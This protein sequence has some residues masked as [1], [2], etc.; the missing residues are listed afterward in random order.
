M[1]NNDEYIRVATTYYKIVHEPNIHDED[2]S[3][4][5][6]AKWDKSSIIDDMGKS[7][8]KKIK[9]YDG[10]INYPS[11]VNYKT[12]V[13]GF[14]NEYHELS[15]AIEKGEFPYT[16]K[17]LKHIFGDFYM[18]GLD[19]LSILWQKPTQLL[20]V[21]CLVSLNRN[22]GKTTF[23]NWLR[24]LFESNVAIIKKVDFKSRFNEAWINKL[25]V[26]VD[27]AKFDK[28]EETDY[29]KELSTSKTQQREKK[30]VDQKQENYFGKIILAS[31]NIDDFIVVD[32]NEIRFW[33]LDVNE[34]NDYIQDFDE[35]L[36]REIPHIKYFLE[37]RKIKYPNSSRMWFKAKD[38]KT[39]ALQRVVRNSYDVDEKELAMIIHEYIELS[40][41]ESVKLALNDIKH[42]MQENKSFISNSSIT[43]IIRDKWNL[44]PSNNA[45]T[46]KYYYKINTGFEETIQLKE[47]NKKGRVYTFHKDHLNGLI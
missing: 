27:E 15:G 39:D 3:F 44:A 29:I 20:P 18:M 38:I 36:K 11:H 25:I 35:K 7:Y 24:T 43:K 2:H 40:E 45:T 33:V 34:I 13:K 42:F 8:I 6:L 32:K 30:G 26:A 31:N 37:N 23:L 21:L 5:R 41:Q 9:R 12:E 14:Y 10:F 22:T 19:Y 1:K 28:R 17:L 47:M 16:E 46:Y 4:K